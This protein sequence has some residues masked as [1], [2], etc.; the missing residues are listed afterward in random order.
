MIIIILHQSE[1]LKF[2]NLQKKLISNIKIPDF[3]LYQS[4]PLWIPL[5]LNDE[6]ITNLKIIAKSISF[7]KIDEVFFS[8]E[9]KSI[10]AN[11]TISINNTVINSQLKLIDF[12]PLKKHE[13]S[14]K[15][16]EKCINGWLKKIC[17][18][19][20]FLP[21]IPK[22]FRIAKTIIQSENCQ[23][24]ENSQWVKLKNN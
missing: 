7:L 13:I 10:N 6:E 14:L 5:N 17:T 18:E 19:E 21:C 1:I 20:L 12:L 11:V 8:L 4:L 24:V 16:Q 3:I 23:A 2:V 22:V 15:E 9:N